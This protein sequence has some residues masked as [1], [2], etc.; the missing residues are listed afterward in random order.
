[1]NRLAHVIENV[2]IHTKFEVGQYIETPGASVYE[3]IEV[4]ME[5]ISATKDA[6]AND[7]V[8]SFQKNSPYK[9]KTRGKTKVWKVTLRDP[10]N[11]CVFDLNM[12]TEEDVNG[13]RAWG[14]N[15]HLI[16]SEGYAR[17]KIQERIKSVEASKET[18]W[19][20]RKRDLS[21]P[22]GWTPDT[23]PDVD[24]EGATSLPDVLRRE[25]RQWLAKNYTAEPDSHPLTSSLLV[26]LDQ[27]MA[28]LEIE[29][30]LTLEK[31][32]GMIHLFHDYAERR[33]HMHV[34]ERIAER[35]RKEFEAHLRGD[36]V[37]AKQPK[38]RGRKQ[39]VSE[40]QE[41]MFQ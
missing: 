7:E 27:Y 31:V 4:G 24:R 15:N 13:Q 32:R 2:S 22:E 38:R 14:L 6:P 18:S 33:G 35:K 20:P 9:K 41:R 29:A 5:T 26:F 17:R 40:D 8:F 10:V 12:A 21:V 34:Y 28:T 23:K 39:G 16:V 1:M 30:D 19:K 37:K 3:V 25:A 11:N 36:P